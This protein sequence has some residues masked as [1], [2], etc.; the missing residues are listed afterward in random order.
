MARSLGLIVLN[1]LLIL[2]GLGAGASPSAWAMDVTLK[3]QETA[4]VARTQDPCRNG[5]P[6]VPGAVTDEK[7]LR[8]LDDK[9]AEVPAQFRV[10]N[11][12]PAGDIEWVCVAFLADV[13]PTGTRPT[14]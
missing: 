2:A 11:R 3:V 4:G 9:G 6:L 14:T 5:V 10:I 12:R 7:K 1:A 13:R 8:L